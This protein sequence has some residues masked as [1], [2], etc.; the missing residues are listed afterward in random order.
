MAGWTDVLS[1]AAGGLISGIGSIFSANAQ[2]KSNEKMFNQ[3]LE[4]NKQE[5]QRQRLFTTSER[6][7]S[8][9]YQTSERE[10]QNRY[11][12]DMYNK[13]QSPAALVQQYKD[14]GLNPRL[15]MDSSS[16][17]NISASSGSSG[18]APSGESYSPL[19]V[20][21][22]YNQVQ[23]YTSGFQDMANA[24]K[25]LGEAKKTGIETDFLED[26]IKERLKGQ[27]LSNE[28]NEL[29]NLVNKKYLNK[30]SSAELQKLLNDVAHGDVEI[31]VLKT[32]LKGFEKDN[33]IKGYEADK[34]LESYEQNV[35]KTESE[36]QLN[37]AKEVHEYISSNYEA[38]QASNND[39]QR[40]LLRAEINFKHSSSDVNETVKSLNSSYEQ[41]NKLTYD[42][43]HASKDDE[44]QRIRS[45]AKAIIEKAES[46]AKRL[47][48]KNEYQDMPYIGTL[49]NAYEGWIEI[50]GKLLAPA[51]GLARP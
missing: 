7:A 6:N 38:L 13:Y 28:A 37:T 1:S 33:I 47:K 35:R 21:P 45:E 12:E 39:L 5:A 32:Q 25:A 30:K 23:S 11:A 51:V 3:Q 29:L 42:I 46:D 22:P 9:L 2:R 14:A 19:G 20:N 17:G 26:E 8:Q 24:V 18:G 48:D 41:L 36:I 27:K 50:S 10:A 40:A 44:V 43:K 31:D 34:W 49:L 15:A 4:Y 16:V